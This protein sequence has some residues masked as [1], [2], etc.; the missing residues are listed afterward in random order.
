MNL[1]VTAAVALA[2]IRHAEEKG[3]SAGLSYFFA[4]SASFRAVLRISSRLL[5]GL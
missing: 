4:A 1:S 3:L 2:D 5:P